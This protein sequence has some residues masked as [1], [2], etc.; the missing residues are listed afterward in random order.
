M[1]ALAAELA[2]AQT[3]LWVETLVVGLNLCP[4]A[5]REL[6][7]DRIRFQVS[8]ATTEE[9][10]IADL[11]GELMLLGDRPAIETTLLIH[12][13]V[14]TDFFSYHRFLPWANRLLTQLGLKGAYQIASFH[15][16]YQFSHSADEDVANYTN[17]SPHPMLHLIREASLARAIANYPDVEGIP[18]R[19]IA[20]LERLG[21]DRVLALLGQCVGGDWGEAGG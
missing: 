18:E 3:K 9:Q 13:W 5:K 21:K 16:Q 10:L 2:A 11:E 20:T 7:K 4:F 12:P 15:P 1:A 6:V 19:N 8:A 17:R 14:L